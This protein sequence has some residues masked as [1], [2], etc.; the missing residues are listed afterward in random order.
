MGGLPR[1][2]GTSTERERRERGAGPAAVRRDDRTG[3]GR[4]GA[5]GRPGTE[6]RGAGGRRA[7]PRPPAPAPPRWEAVV[8]SA[9]GQTAR[10]S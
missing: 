5:G 7:A 10:S 1:G 6:A 4:A 9:G 3:P 2:P 8:S